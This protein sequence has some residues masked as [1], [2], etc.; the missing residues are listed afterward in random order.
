VAAPPYSRR[1]EAALATRPTSAKNLA[2]ERL[3]RLRA[4]VS[5]P[6]AGQRNRR[7]GRDPYHFRPLRILVL[8]TYYPEFLAAHYRARRELASYSYELQLASLMDRCFGTSDA[9]SSHL[10]ELGHEAVEVVANCEP[11]QLRWAS[12]QGYGRRVL[13]GL[14]AALPSP[15]RLLARRAALRRIALEQIETFDPQVVYLQD[16]WFFKGRDLDALRRDG[17]FVAGQIASAL[18]PDRMLR[19]FDLLVTSFPHFVE[20]FREKGLDS[21]YLKIAFYRKVLERLQGQGV[22]PDPAAPRDYG[23]AFVGGLDP[24]VHGA[25]ARLLERLAREVDLDVWGYGAGRLPQGSAI[26]RR[27]HGEAWGLEMY[28]VLA[29]SRIALNRHIELSDGYAN[30]MRLFEATGVGALLVTDAKRNL[31]NLF[32]PGRELVAYEDEDDLVDKLRHFAEHDDERRHIATAG[33]ERTLREHTYANRMTELA[34]ML[35]ARLG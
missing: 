10:R 33:Q 12:E 30:N 24:R 35:K 9:Y 25:G 16:L 3:I 15:M 19:R 21:E 29:R 17:R 8:D 1:C 7:G 22:Q 13:Q 11:L 27:Y 5:E 2:P 31:A 23:V 14:G 18:P 4:A 28:K 32:E 34:A 20:R 6:I 26:A